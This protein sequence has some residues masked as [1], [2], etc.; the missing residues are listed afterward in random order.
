MRKFLAAAAILAF[1]GQVLAAETVIGNAP[2]NGNVSAFGFPDSQTFGQVFTAPVSD[3][4][5]SFTL[6]IGSGL[7]SN[8]VGVLGTWNGT[9]EWAEGFGSPS[10]LYTSALVPAAGG[11]SFTFTPN[12]AVTA[13]TRYVAY[14]T[15]FGQQGR[16]ST[17]MPLGDDSDP[18]LDYF[19]WNN[20]SDA[21]NNPGWNYFLDFGDAHF[22]AT[23]GTAVPEPQSW[24]L[25][26]AGFG[27][28]GAAARRRR[29]V[30][31][32]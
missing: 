27:L 21:R 25:L 26:I 20:A 3:V 18:W 22:D 31:T 24:A 1:S 8:M 7:T 28:I 5:T 14:I 13:G 2:A 29:M 4:M 15:V 23:F 30:A 12:V 11:G 16:G 32:A 17:S 19:V 9:A 6:R 10:T